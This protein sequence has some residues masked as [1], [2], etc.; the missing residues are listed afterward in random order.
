MM[1]FGALLFASG[2]IIFALGYNEKVG[3]FFYNLVGRKSF[4]NKRYFEEDINNV[5]K[6]VENKPKKKNKRK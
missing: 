1:I 6:T 3:I 2:V 4:T 5:I